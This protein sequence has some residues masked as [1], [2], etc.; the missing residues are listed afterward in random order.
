MK[1]KKKNRA[2]QTREN[3]I[4]WFW[5]MKRRMAAKS[6]EKAGARKEKQSRLEKLCQKILRQRGR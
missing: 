6:L 1:K 3:N 5:K 2:F 4:A